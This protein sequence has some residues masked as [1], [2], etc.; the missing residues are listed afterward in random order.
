MQYDGFLDYFHKFNSHV[1]LVNSFWGFERALCAPPNYI[2]TGPLS[3]PQESLDLGAKDPELL[4][5]LDEALEKGQDVAY[6]SIGSIAKW[7]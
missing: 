5:F 2:L 4:S 3:K 6:I 7:E 1:I